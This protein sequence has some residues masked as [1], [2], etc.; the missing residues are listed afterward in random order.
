MRQYMN[1]DVIFLGIDDIKRK[2]KIQTVLKKKK[3][4]GKYPYLVNYKSY[5]K[6]KK[7]ISKEDYLKEKTII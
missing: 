6:T 4:Q 1:S 3:L 5:M 7:N 2:R